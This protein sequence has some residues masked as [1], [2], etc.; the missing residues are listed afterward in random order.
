MSIDDICVGPLCF[1]SYSYRVILETYGI[2]SNTSF[3]LRLADAIYRSRKRVVIA[4]YMFGL[5]K[6]ASRI[7]RALRR[8][9]NNGVRVKIILDGSSGLATKTNCKTAR[10]LAGKYGIKNIIFT[11]KRLHAKIYIVDSVMWIGSA[12]LG[13]QE[14]I[15]VMVQIDSSDIIKRIM[16]MLDEIEDRYSVDPYAL[17]INAMSGFSGSSYSGRADL[18]RH[19][20][21]EHQSQQESHSDA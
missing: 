5:S 16:D 21:Q 1:H 18:L 20:Q 13:F 7:V 2:G 9:V 10:R 19:A 3:T 6:Y 12:N 8:A 4:T 14:S 11:S 17:C 15:E